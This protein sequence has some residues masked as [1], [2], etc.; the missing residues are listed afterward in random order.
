MSEPSRPNSRFRYRFTRIG[1]H[2]AFVA[3]FA[4]VGGSIRGFNLLLVLAGFLVAVLIVQWRSSRGAI[5]CL[6]ARRR[7]PQETYAGVAFRI[8]YL[9]KNHSHWLSVWMVRV[10]DVIGALG[11]SRVT[12]APCAVGCVRPGETEPAFFD[13]LI[14][15][16]GRYELG[17]IRCST[18]Y[19]F[20][21]LTSSQ[22]TEDVE[23]LYVYPKRLQLRQNWQRNLPARAGHATASGRRSGPDEG[24]FFGLREWKSGDS[25]RWI[26]WRTTARTM[27]PVVRQF[28]Q[29]TR[30][31][32]CALVDAFSDSRE[33]LR[34]CETAISLAGTLLTNVNS[35][36]GQGAKSRFTL[37]LANQSSDVFGY[38]QSAISQH[39]MMRA[40]TTLQP[41][42]E[43]NVADAIRAASKTLPQ[44]GDLLII[45]SRSLAIAQASDPGLSLAIGQWQRHGAVKWVDVSQELHRWVVASEGPGKAANERTRMAEAV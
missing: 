37:A 7:L 3:L 44:R 28:E 9:I 16:R 41:T 39:A 21:L 29:S 24:D 6:S 22:L 11:S 45:S 38:S 20:A 36:V 14:S 26:H 15:K 32:V 40:L 30:L 2:F 8:T 5:E 34:A 42:K 13:C 17:P 18:S 35:S 1:I 19:P 25:P 23:L 43:S 10:D 33:S 4:M 27:T 31:D 12:H